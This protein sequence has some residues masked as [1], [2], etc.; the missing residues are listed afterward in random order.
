MAAEWPVLAPSALAPFPWPLGGWGFA[1]F[2][3]SRWL[4]LVGLWFGGLLALVRLLA[5]PC[6]VALAWLWSPLVS[7]FDGRLFCF[8]LSLDASDFRLWWPS[9]PTLKVSTLC[10]VSSGMYS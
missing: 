5:F 1:A 7:G 9:L 2:S 4:A 10:N 8:L 3:Y 6:F